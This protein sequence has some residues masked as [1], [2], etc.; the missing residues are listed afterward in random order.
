MKP[1]IK[2]GEFA[3][4]EEEG[5]KNI[6]KSYGWTIASDG[7]LF[8]LVAGDMGY[9]AT[10]IV[11]PKEYLAALFESM[12]GDGILE[13][14]VKDERRLTNLCKTFITEKLNEN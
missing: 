4:S 10:H 11:I 5:L 8:G 3:V 9:E 7:T 14:S 13:I 12:F 1:R 6:K 2:W